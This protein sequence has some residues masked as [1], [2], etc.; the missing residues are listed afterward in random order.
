MNDRPK[1]HR[2]LAAEI[3]AKSNPP[4]MLKKLEE[5]NPSLAGQI[6]NEIDLTRRL[7]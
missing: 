7:K 3:V 4:E 6:K 1:S 5:K 2:E